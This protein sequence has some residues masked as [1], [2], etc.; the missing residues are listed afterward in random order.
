MTMENV[1]AA[2]SKFELIMN[3]SS[4]WMIELVFA[5]SEVFVRRRRRSICT[6][7]TTSKA[8]EV[9]KYADA[10]CRSRRNRAG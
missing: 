6:V 1:T 9:E 8:A 3:R 4:L 7:M 5:Y 2:V 10:T